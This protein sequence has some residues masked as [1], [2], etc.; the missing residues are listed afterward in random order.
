M[1]ER[2]NDSGSSAYC[3]AFM[4]GRKPSVMSSSRSGSAMVKRTPR[5]PSGSTLTT[6]SKALR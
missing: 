6:F 4:I 5:S 1:P 2:K 3:A